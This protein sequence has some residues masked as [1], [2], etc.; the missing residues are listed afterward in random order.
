MIQTDVARPAER[1]TAVTGQERARLTCTFPFRRLWYPGSIIISLSSWPLMPLMGMGGSWLEKRSLIPVDLLFANRQKIAELCD[2]TNVFIGGAHPR[3]DQHKRGNKWNKIAWIIDLL[4]RF[5]T[6]VYIDFD[7]FVV[8]AQCE[9]MDTAKTNTNTSYDLRIA[10]D[11]K[12]PAKYNS[13]VMVAS[14]SA[15]FFFERVWRYNDGGK[16]ISDQR[17][18]NHVLK[19]GDTHLDLGVLH[20]KYNA[21]P[22]PPRACDDYVPPRKGSRVDQK[23]VVIRHYAGEYMGARSWPD[24]KISRCAWQQLNFTR[25]AYSLHDIV[26]PQS[27][28][29]TSKSRAERNTAILTSV[30]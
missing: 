13:G 19:R 26:R 2:V 9:W 25:D 15:R 7:A 6:V 1:E 22:E 16:G 27:G 8:K 10:R 24:G 4:R 14:S 28:L 30:T 23:D 17:S 5:D 18:I 11:A 20:P 29:R 21:F 12:D 3:V